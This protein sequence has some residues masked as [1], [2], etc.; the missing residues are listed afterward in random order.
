MRMATTPSEN[1]REEDREGAEEAWVPA[2]EMEIYKDENLVPDKDE[3][4][5]PETS[6]T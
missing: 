4:L 3:N 2:V 1:S 6:L 5:V